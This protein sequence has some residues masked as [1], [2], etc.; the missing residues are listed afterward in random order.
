MLGSLAQLHRPKPPRQRAEELQPRY[1]VSGR[2][3]RSQPLSSWHA[4]A[5]QPVSPAGLRTRRGLPASFSRGARAPC[6]PG[7]QL[8]RGVK[9]TWPNGLRWLQASG[10]LLPRHRPSRH[11]PSSGPP[12]AQ[13]VLPRRAGGGARLRRRTSR[14]GPRGRKM[15]RRRCGTSR[16][17]MTTCTARSSGSSCACSSWVGE[18]AGSRQPRRVAARARAHARARLR[19]RPLRG[20]PLRRRRRRWTPSARCRLSCSGRAPS[21]R[22]SAPGVR[23]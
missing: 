16:R 9:G 2:S 7:S 4:A 18:Q 10:S 13:G 17:R 15:M 3:Q 8:L 12:P 21:S 5:V 20:L 14:F 23:S 22:R 6:P 11:R 19:G 1:W